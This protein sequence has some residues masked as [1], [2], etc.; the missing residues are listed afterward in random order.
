[1]KMQVNW[2]LAMVGCCAM[3]VTG[4]LLFSHVLTTQQIVA[5][6]PLLWA[7]PSPLKFGAPVAATANAPEADIPPAPPPSVGGT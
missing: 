4:A 1:M 5:V 2:P 7:I 6:A 3:I